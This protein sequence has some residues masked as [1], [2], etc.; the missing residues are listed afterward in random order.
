[1]V[2]CCVARGA[3][4]SDVIIRPWP[5]RSYRIKKHIGKIQIQ[6]AHTFSSYK[7]SFK[8]DPDAE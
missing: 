2:I 4:E 6:E 8:I 7:S 5:E 3:G 1:M